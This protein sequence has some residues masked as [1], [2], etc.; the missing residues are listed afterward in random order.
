MCLG[1]KQYRKEMAQYE[2]DRA[3]EE[4][5]IPQPV[6]CRKATAAELARCGKTDFIPYEDNY[7]RKFNHRWKEFERTMYA[8]ES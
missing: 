5:E 7:D 2:I 6:T 4:S 3:V 8:S 1:R